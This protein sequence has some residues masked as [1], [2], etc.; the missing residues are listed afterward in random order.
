MPPRCGAF[1]CLLLVLAAGGCRNDAPP[2]DYPC[3]AETGTAGTATLA[4]DVGAVESAGD[5]DG[6]EDVDWDDEGDSGGPAEGYLADGPY[7][8]E[9]GHG[10]LG[11]G[12]AAAKAAWFVD[13]FPVGTH[14]SS[15]PWSDHE[16]YHRTVAPYL[17]YV[18]G[19][20]G[21]R[22]DV[23]DGA[24]RVTLMFTEPSFPEPGLRVFDVSSHGV[25]LLDDLDLAA[26]AGQDQIVD[27]AVQ[28]LAR[29]GAI[30]LQLKAETDEPPVLAGLRIEPAVEGA[31]N[32]PA[33][34]ESR[35]GGGEGLLRWAWPS[36][37]ARGWLVARSIA[38]GDHEAVSGQLV[39][40][41]SFVDRDRSAGE[42]LSYRVWP[43]GAD[44]SAGP[45]ADS[46]SITV[47]DVS[48]LGLPVI[49]VT[50]DAAEFA[51]IHADPTEDLEAAMTVTSGSDSGSGIIRL[52]GQSTRWVPKRSF[53][54]KLDSG[55]LDGRDRLKLLAEQNPPSR[56]WQLAAY[57]LFAR[58]GSVASVARP[59]VLRINGQVYG[60]YDDIEHVGDDY[61]ESRGYGVDDRFRA[62]YVD[63]GLRY[64]DQGGV[65]LEGFEKKANETEPS[66]ELEQLL[67]WLNTAAEHQ[68][69]EE[70]EQ[71]ID[72]DVMVDYM[73]GQ[74]LIANPEVIDGAHYLIL[75]PASGAFLMAPWD[76]NNDT[77]DRSWLP[78]ANNTAY[79][80]G[81]G[82]HYWLWTRLM[83]STTFREQ[84]VARLEV[85]ATGVFAQDTPGRID[86]F[87]QLVGP[88]LAVE[89][90]LFTRR[91]EA[92]VA[93]GPPRMHAFIDERAA[94]LSGE[95]AGFAQLGATGPVIVS[96][97]GGS[98]ASVSI[99][100]R[101][102]E[103]ISL[104]GCHLATDTYELAMLELEGWLEPGAA[105]TREFD[106]IEPAGG[107]LVLSCGE[108]EGEGEG[109]EEE[110]G[111]LITSIVFYPTL[112][113]GEEYRR[114]GDGWAVG[115]P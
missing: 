25:V 104:T 27:I 93:S 13:F 17:S 47:V 41:P 114:T 23:P 15:N 73:A 64:D 80:A 39:L 96:V 99:E 59:V 2:F 79:A 95:L 82:F 48:E 83:G 33:S 88:A 36:E 35:A 107:Y 56:L 84:L 98:G 29:D 113:D 22:V 16:A 100:N 5:D 4:I 91:Y 1:V 7:D 52:R 51:A 24:Y 90:F 109:D 105:A 106:G 38:G 54:L 75:D 78:L 46:A 112:A 55:T 50:V 42:Q 45:P 20:T 26:R 14:D 97:T 62:G 67:I 11:D 101:G 3:D 19:L 32:A 57:D 66:P 76:L 72:V 10:W 30:E 9:R 86:S 70:L 85:L 60:V 37:P 21:Y 77:W 44:C 111:A 89:P 53:Y 49:D 8:A 115:S 61:L 40:S 69:E 103:E 6:A 102:D 94:N 81:G 87:E 110:G 108:G 31:G 34:L 71:T 63:F 12:E 18:S 68:L 28:V 43:V 65:D 74:I 58:M 92:W